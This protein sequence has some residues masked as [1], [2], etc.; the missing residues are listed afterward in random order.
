MLPFRTTGCSR[1][2]DADALVEIRRY[3][4][5]KRYVYQCQTCGNTSSALPVK[6]LPI[7]EFEIINQDLAVW[8]YK[9][10]ARKRSEE[11]ERARDEQSRRW[12]DEYNEYLASDAW[13]RRRRWVLD[14]AAGRCEAWVKCL[15]AAATQVH[16]LS[17]AHLGAEPLWELQAV[18][19]ACHLAITRMDRESRSA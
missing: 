18:C 12:W 17:Y 7:A 1:C 13:K 4:G 19:E 10:L 6:S 8:Y 2:G 9:E 3:E 11:H 15:G 5:I 14:R 16:H